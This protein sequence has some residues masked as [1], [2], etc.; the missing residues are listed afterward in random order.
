M[1]QR[2]V[3]LGA[4]FA[5]LQLARRLPSQNFDVTLIDQY[6]F[7]QFQP[8]FYQVATARLEPSMISFP[9]RKVFQRSNVHV[10]VAHAKHINTE[11]QQICTNRG[12]YPYD[13]L[14]IATG[15]T[16]NFFGNKGFEEYAF[17][18]K[19]TNESIRLRNRILTNFED[20]LDASPEDLEGLMNIVIAGGGP[21]GVE[22]AGSLAEMKRYVLPRDYPDMDFSGLR[23]YLLEGKDDT[24]ATMSEA[25]RK[26]SCEYL[27]ELG[28][29]VM[30]ST[31][32][33]S[34]DGHR[35]QLANGNSI[36]TRTLIWTAGVTGNRLPGLPASAE[37]KGNRISVNNYCL[38]TG[39]ANIYA[40]GDVAFMETEGY[41]NGHPQVANVAINQA[42]TLALNLKRA[43]KSRNPVP[44]RYRDP[45]SMATI[46][47]HKAVVD[48]PYASFQ[49]RIAWFAW[50]F[51]HLM[52]ILSVRN[53]V[54]IFFNWAY[55]Y[56]TNDTTLRLILEPRK[57]TKDK[58]TGY[59][60]DC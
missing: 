18:M 55:N 3:I 44:F 9:L 56:F 21:T 19:S 1:K 42:R 60:A 51:L 14:V 28:V 53:K 25:S 23:I 54:F 48:L 50:M 7:H 27:R 6:N 13:I 43:I 11:D 47:K 20:A 15:C 38:V 40:L 22:L 4:G 46:G 49:G 10:R 2:I 5:G 57:E 41:P 59:I 52:L 31:L 37:A 12:N 24:L 35:L 33:S 17:T 30:T 32:A 16:T 26:K 29:D 45:G 36:Q 58:S 8:L 39:T 34:Y